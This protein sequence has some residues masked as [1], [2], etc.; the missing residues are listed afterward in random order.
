MSESLP[1]EIQAVDLG[2]GWRY[3][4]PLRQLGRYRL[5]GC[6]PL[7]FGGLF[8]AMPAFLG[9]MAGIRLLPQGGPVVW[10]FALFAAF[11]L[12]F[13]LAGMFLMGIGVFVL[14]GHSEIEIHHGRLSAIERAG[15]LRWKRWRKTASVRRFH[16]GVGRAKTHNGV[17]AGPLAN[18]GGLVAELDTG[19]PFLLAFGYTREMLRPLAEELSGRC[20]LMLDEGAM[21]GTRPPVEVVEV[22]LDPSAFR[23]RHEQPASSKVM[24]ERAADGVTLS[25]PPA[26]LW[27]GSKGLF[28]LSVFWLGISLAASGGLGGA[29]V[30][31]GLKGMGWGAVFPLG[32]CTLFLG[33]GIAMLLAAINMGRQ[34]AVLAVVGGSLMVLQTGIFG[35]KRGEWDR[36]QVADIRT[37][38]SGL[39]SGSE[40]N[41]KPIIQLQ[42]HLKSG[43]TF[44]ML[45]GRDDAELFWLATV[46]RKALR[47]PVDQAQGAHSSAGSG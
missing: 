15:W 13:V 2:N 21:M 38:P 7:A 41:Q 45:T 24:C 1:P 37:G 18:A 17:A 31:G 34:R 25:V 22:P 12:L 10:F 36:D 14:A 33:I 5:I 11:L 42:I 20:N 43:R 32:L 26:G 6:L 28:L 39:S 47:R 27:R 19:K 29:A 40:G 46:L 35:S 8:S 9:I 16:L 3:V 4:L 30:G 23:E 44:G